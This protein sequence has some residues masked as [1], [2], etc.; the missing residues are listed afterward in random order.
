MKYKSKREFEKKFISKWTN[1][2]IYNKNM[3]FDFI[4]DK[5]TKVEEKSFFHFYF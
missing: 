3:T 1:F 5:S 2:F 4:K